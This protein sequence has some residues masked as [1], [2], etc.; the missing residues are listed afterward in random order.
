[1]FE[2]VVL[3]AAFAT[4]IG[5]A[6][7]IRSMFRGQ[8]RPNR[9]TWFMWS[10]AP[11]IVAS[12]AISNGVGW[13]VV[14]VLMSGISPLM[15]LIASFFNKKAYWKPSTFDYLCGVISGLAL[16]FWYITSD[17]NSA[18]ILG[19][20]SDALAAVPTITKAW[21]YP[22]SESIWPFA[23]GLF[24]PMTSFLVATTWSFS[25]IAFP[26]YLIAINSLLV[27]PILKKPKK[28][29]FE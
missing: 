24:S 21:R 9:V 11:L 6:L 8:T 23:I 5:A 29:P 18:I 28:Y 7:Y 26:S 19:M 20:T 25:E 2:F 10:V 14:P 4:L 1:M 3:T 13:A 16:V 17:P 12:A 15:V 27:I 22:E